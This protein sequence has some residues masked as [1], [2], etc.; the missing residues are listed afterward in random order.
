MA[1]QEYNVSLY[2]YIREEKG[3]FKLNDN[4]G[5]RTHDCKPVMNKFKAGNY[6]RLFKWE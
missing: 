4:V 5:T 2:I 3:L 6:R 1:E